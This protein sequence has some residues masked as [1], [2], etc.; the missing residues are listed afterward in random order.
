MKIT[1]IKNENLTMN[2]KIIILIIK[3]PIHNKLL[4]IR[5]L[6]RMKI[7][8]RKR[9][10]LTINNKINILKLIYLRLEININPRIIINHFGI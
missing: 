4:K 1:L 10:K 9:E 2:N 3:L 5:I 7:L 6:Y 8:L